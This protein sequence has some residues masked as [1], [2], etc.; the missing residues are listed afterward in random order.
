MLCCPVD[1][2][3]IYIYDY[4][5]CCGAKPHLLPLDCYVDVHGL[6][7]QSLVANNR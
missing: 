2:N 6:R 5:C 3:C 4:S 1:S 7:G